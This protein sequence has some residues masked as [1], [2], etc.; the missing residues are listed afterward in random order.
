LRRVE[1]LRLCRRRDAP[2]LD[3]LRR[4]DVAH[5]YIRDN[6]TIPYLALNVVPDAV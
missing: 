4:L 3:N 1:H 5:E 2:L 6:R